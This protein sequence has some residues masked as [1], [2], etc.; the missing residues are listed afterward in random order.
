M[1][2]LFVRV[3]VFV[4]VALCIYNYETFIYK[5]KLTLQGVMYLLLCNDKGYKKS[6]IAQDVFLPS[7]DKAVVEKKTIIFV[8]HGEST[9]NDTFNKGSHRSTTQFIIGYIPGLIKAI[10]YEIYLLITGKMDRYVMSCFDKIYIH[11]FF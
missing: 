3:L 8:R 6:K 7:L 5:T 1:L 2:E 9:W 4:F 10:C 11:I